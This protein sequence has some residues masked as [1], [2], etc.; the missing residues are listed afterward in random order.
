MNAKAQAAS[1]TGVDEGQIMTVGA[2]LDLLRKQ[3]ILIDLTVTGTS[4]FTR[5]ANFVE[6]GIRDEAK[7]KRYSPGTKYLIPKEPVGKIKSVEARMRQALEYFT[8]DIRGFK[9]YKW[10]SY[11]AWPKWVERWEELHSEFEEIKAYILDHWDYYVDLLVQ[12]FATSAGETWDSAVSQGYDAI[13]W[14]Q[15]AYTNKTDFIDAVV[16]LS[17]SRL[18]TKQDVRDNLKADYIV[19]VVYGAQDYAADQAQAEKIKAQAKKESYGDY[20]EHKELEEK[21]RHDMKMNQLA[22]DERQAKIEAMFHAEM[23]HAKKQIQELGSPL[24]EVVAELRNQVAE[25]AE[26]MLKSIKRNG[27]VRGKIAQKGAGLIEF[28]DLMATHNDKALKSKLEALKLQIGP[29]G[30]RSKNTPERNVEA[31]SQTLEEISSLATDNLKDITEISRAA[32]L[33][34]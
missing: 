18:P 21:I 32:F 16:D 14:G 12:E 22:E 26:S 15:K 33:E 29:I 13:I 17:L 8:R 28:Y 5:T 19:G 34:L 27:F 4:M 25:D 1:I 24:A 6:L 7:L 31:I 23:E 11:T 9:P 3:G 10:L 30:K 2:Q 20:L